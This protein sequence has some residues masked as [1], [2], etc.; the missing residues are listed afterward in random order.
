MENY[1]LKRKSKNSNLQVFEYM[2][3]SYNNVRLKIFVL[4]DI[5]LSQIRDVKYLE[6][7]KKEALSDNFDAIFIAGD[8]LD[9]TNILKTNPKLVNI[10]LDFIKLL[11]E[12]SPTY[13]AYD[14]HDL[15]HYFHGSSPHW[16][17]DKKLFCEK[18]LDIVAGFSNVHVESNQIFSLKFGHTVS[19]LNPNMSYIIQHNPEFLLQDSNLTQIFSYLNPN[20]NNILLCHNPNIFISS[21]IIRVC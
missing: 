8:F 15:C 14:G 6:K 7:V 1:Y 9:Y 3:K 5:H 12:I 21:R 19:I 13:I 16:Q 20:F 11:G 4:S 10:F 17:I 2:S 18:I